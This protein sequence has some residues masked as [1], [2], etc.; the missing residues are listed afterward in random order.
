MPHAARRCPACCFDCMLHA[1][2]KFP[3]HL[4]H[5]E[6]IR[7][8]SEFRCWCKFDVRVSFRNPNAKVREGCAMVMFHRDPS[9][10][11]LHCLSTNFTLNNVNHSSLGCGGWDFSLVAV[12]HV[13]V[14]RCTLAHVTHSL[15]RRRFVF[16]SPMLPARCGLPLAAGASPV[17]LAC[18]RAP[19][20][21]AASAR[22]G[23]ARASCA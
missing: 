7:Y 6:M 21:R 22:R 19:P 10:P 13:C 15:R 4:P 9:H 1:A 18:A 8:C 20:P 16:E 12:W 11:S 14:L 2:G 23:T 5:G 17:L 3:Y